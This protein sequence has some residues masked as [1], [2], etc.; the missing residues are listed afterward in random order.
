MERIG[1]VYRLLA[2][3][4]DL[5]CLLV[6]DLAALTAVYVALAD[7]QP[8]IAK[9]IADQANLP[10][11][12]LAWQSWA[13][14][15]II[16]PLS[17]TTIYCALEIQFRATPGKMIFGLVICHQDGSTPSTVQLAIRAM[18]K[19]SWLFIICSAVIAAKF[20]VGTAEDIL[21]LAPVGL[22]IF[23]LAM[24]TLPLPSKRTLYDIASGTAVFKEP[25]QRSRRRTR[26]MHP[27]LQLAQTNQS[28][29]L[30]AGRNNS[31]PVDE[32]IFK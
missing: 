5:F 32:L 19:Y 7:S 11:L 29:P 25:P 21:K 18:I 30:L 4:L 10:S 22:A 26:E 14:L 8:A 31:R 1:A 17:L 23:I 20:S 16:A 24:F 12:H 6:A 2:F 27:T 9:V 13:I 28:N 3:L 15:L